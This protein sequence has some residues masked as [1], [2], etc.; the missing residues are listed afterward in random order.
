MGNA[1]SSIGDRTSITI[2]RNGKEKTLDI[3]PA[4][5]VEADAKVLSGP[6]LS[7]NLGLQIRPLNP[8]IAQQLRL[9][10]DETGVLVAQVQPNS[11]GAKAGIRQGD[12]I[13]EVNRNPVTSP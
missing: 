7:K 1:E 13:K 11:K 12:V 6:I 8:E 5:R 4:K 9:S 2:I 10:K 3:K